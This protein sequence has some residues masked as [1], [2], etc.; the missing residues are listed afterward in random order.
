MPT[1]VSMQCA[2]PFA[3][4]M[5]TNIISARLLASFL[6]IQ[7]VEEEEVRQGDLERLHN[8]ALLR[9]RIVLD[10]VIID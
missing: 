5:V 8:R 6:L 4:P 2:M 10:Y 3:C 1:D 7:M 9:R